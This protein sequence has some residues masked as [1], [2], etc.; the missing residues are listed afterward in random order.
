[1]RCL[2]GASRHA[3]WWQCRRGTKDLD[4]QQPAQLR[5]GVTWLAQC[6]EGVLQHPAGA[7]SASGQLYFEAQEHKSS[8]DSSNC[9]CVLII[10]ISATC[11]SSACRPLNPR[12]FKPSRWPQVL[13]IHTPASHAPC[14]KSDPSACRH[15]CSGPLRKR[16][17]FD[18]AC[19]LLCCDSHHTNAAKV[20]SR[21]RA[22]K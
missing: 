8:S 9:L 17:A 6:R 3:P 12:S 19:H 16:S 14:P 11:H 2:L 21:H 1:M 15:D 5:G 7:T 4:G 22:A 18:S 13:A 10:T 20:S